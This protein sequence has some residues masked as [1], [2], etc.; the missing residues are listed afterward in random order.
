MPRLLGISVEQPAPFRFTCLLFESFIHSSI[1]ARVFMNLFPGPLDVALAL[2]ACGPATDYAMVQVCICHHFCA[3]L[4]PL[5]PT[6]CSLLL[7][8]WH[9]CDWGLKQLDLA[10]LI[11]NQWNEV[12]SVL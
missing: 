12:I 10:V 9:A 3:A 7:A 8:S 1:H 5:L 11:A 2:H 4:L 6:C